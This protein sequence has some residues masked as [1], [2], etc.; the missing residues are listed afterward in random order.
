MSKS[1]AKH[2]LLE[3]QCMPQEKY[4][5]KKWKYFFLGLVTIIVLVHLSVAACQLYM[6]SSQVVTVSSGRLTHWWPEP[7]P[8]N[9]VARVA[10]YVVHTSDWCSISTISTA[11]PIK[12]Y[13]FGSI[14][15]VSDGPVDK[16]SGTPYAYITRLDLCGKDLLT[17][18]RASLA[19]SEAQSDYCKTVD[20]DPEDPRCARVLLSGTVEEL[21][22]G[23]SEAEFAKEALFSR[24]P[25]MKTWPQKNHNWIFVKMNIKNIYVFDYFG[26][27]RNVAVEDYYNA[28]L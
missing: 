12:G 13:P 15:S 28:E 24:H 16:S 27:V 22:N 25:V 20:L 7:P 11:D 18:D 23:T 14:L 19:V 4:S 8:H 1:E 2:S 26:G 6:S 21:K 10:R 3:Q 17:D 5:L 9:Q